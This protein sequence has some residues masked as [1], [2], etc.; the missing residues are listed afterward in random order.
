MK[1]NLSALSTHCVFLV[2]KINK[3][4]V[5]TNKKSLEG[6]TQNSKDS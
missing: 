2:G 1:D 6:T 5:F 4:L 3:I